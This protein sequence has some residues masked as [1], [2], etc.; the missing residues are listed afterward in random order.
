MTVE[1]L[2]ADRD[3]AEVFADENSGNVS[4]DVQAIGDCP[5]EPPPCRA[6]VVEVLA[7]WD[8]SEQEWNGWDG[9]G[10]FLL[11]DGRYLAAS[12]SCDYTGWD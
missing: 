9:A 2:L 3:W 5:A 10:V 4:K 12:G 7:S 11:R 6:D 8:T 1:E